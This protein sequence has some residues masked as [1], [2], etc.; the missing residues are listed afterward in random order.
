MSPCGLR[1]TFLLLQLNVKTRK[2]FRLRSF[3]LLRHS[4]WNCEGHTLKIFSSRFISCV[5]S[6]EI[7]FLQ[8][9]SV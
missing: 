7:K 5:V 4:T 9:C 1:E 6:G 8:K 2:T 3:H